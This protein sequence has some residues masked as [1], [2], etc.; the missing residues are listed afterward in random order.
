M[1]PLSL[2]AW[3][4]I[5]CLLLLFILCMFSSRYSLLA[6]FYVTRMWEMTYKSANAITRRQKRKDA[7][8]N[9]VE[10]DSKANHTTWALPKNTIEWSEFTLPEEIHMVKPYISHINFL[11]HMC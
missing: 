7:K 4:F 3:S 1:T 2:I 9:G 5:E 11:K 10:F 8:A 6:Y